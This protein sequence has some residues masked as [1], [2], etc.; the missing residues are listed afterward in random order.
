MYPFEIHITVSTSDIDAFKDACYAIGV[1]PI[2][3]DLT[4]QEGDVT[5][6]RDVMTSSEIMCPDISVFL[7]VDRIVSLLTEKGFQVVRKKIET[8]PWHPIV[9]TIELDGTNKSN[10][11]ECHFAISTSRDR[12]Q[13]LSTFAKHNGCH[14]SKNI[15]KKED[16][17]RVIMMLT[18][19][20]YTGTYNDF[21]SSIQQIEK[22][23]DFACF[24][25]NK[26]II[27]F[28]IYDTNVSHDQKWIG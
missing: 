25:R 14:R 3:I 28:A 12:L 10:Y 21:V 18:K 11:F 17:D 19:R 23:L 15:F 8:V 13:E 2:V 26:T 1:K 7:E 16:A 20:A 24:S 6:L 9:K 27:E 4:N 5:V 22:S